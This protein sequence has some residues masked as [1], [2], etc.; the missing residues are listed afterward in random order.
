MIS[1]NIPPA[2]AAAVISVEP[3][4]ITGNVGE[5]FTVDIL[6]TGLTSRCYSFQIY[7]AYDSSI[8]DVNRWWEGPFL[9]GNPATTLQSYFSYNDTDGYDALDWL[10][11]YDK[12]N[13]TYSGFQYSERDGYYGV[14]KF[15]V[16]P[17]STDSTIRK[18]DVKMRYSATASGSGDMYRIVYY[19]GTPSSPGGIQRTLVDWTSAATPLGTY[20]WEDATA[21]TADGWQWTEDVDNLCISVETDMVGGDISAVFELYEVWL[22][23]TYAEPTFTTATQLSD[24]IAMGVAKIGPYDGVRGN[25]LLLSM[26]FIINSMGTVDIDISGAPGDFTYL[27][28]K[29]ASTISTTKVNGLFFEP[30]AEDVYPDGIIDIRDLTVVGRNYGVTGGV[31]VEYTAS[32]SSWTDGGVPWINPGNAVSSNDV[33]ADTPKNGEETYYDY[34]FGTGSWLTVTSVE[35]GVEGY[36]TGGEIIELEV[37]WDG[38]TSWSASAHT[39]VFGASDVLTWVDVTSDH[40]WVPS[41]LSDA[42]FRVRGTV[43]AVGGFK[44]TYVDWLPVRVNVIGAPEGDVN[45]D[46]DVDITD[47]AMVAIKYGTIYL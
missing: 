41:E 15:G 44:A 30:W 22:T 12:N 37:S 24:S 26:E 31:P 3:D 5:T 35:V 21:P 23:I 39:V 20:V 40:A 14:Y 10:K 2:A 28:T 45:G 38:G 6:V 19:T 36:S 29:T 13:D 34:G 16:D 1:I 7:A 4:K 47:L 17:K 46:G 33:Y 8:I 32:P 11:L 43:L 18:V 25:G 27:L 9:K 42:S